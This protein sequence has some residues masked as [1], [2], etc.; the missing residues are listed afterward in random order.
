M[1]SQ[2]ILFSAEGIGKTVHL[3]QGSNITRNGTLKHDKI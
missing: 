3:K 1:Y 2:K